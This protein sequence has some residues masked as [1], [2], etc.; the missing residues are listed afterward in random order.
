M[1]N[2]NLSSE[3]RSVPAS[4]GFYANDITETIGNTPLVRLRRMTADRG[5]KAKVLVKMEFLNPTGSVKDRMVVYVLRQAIKS[6]ELKPGGTI[7]EATSGNTG[8]AVAMFAAVN[9]YKAILTVPDK[10]SREKVD[11]LKAF[12]AKVYICPSDV[13]ADSPE[14]YYETGKRLHRE[15]S[16]SYWLGQYFN[17]NNV[18]AHYRTTGPEIWR[19]TGGQIDVLVGGIGTG[20][21]ISGTG[22]FL[23]EMIQ[24]IEVV[25]ADPV[26][27]IYYNYH[28]NKSLVDPNVYMVEGIGDDMLCP[29]VDFS[30]I[31][32]IY[33]VTDE[34]C[35]KTGRELT[36]LE[37]IFGGGSSGAAVHVA[38]KHAVNLDADKTMV[39]ILP[40]SGM[41][42]MSKMY[43]DDWM[44][45]KGFIQ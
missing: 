14:S 21:T 37:G 26:G 45:S 18:E 9:G 30:I 2:V 15:T 29:T 31:D 24:D 41:K 20:G 19:Q 27:S 13:S 10:M 3:G 35:F 1:R 28:K 39:V 8:A 4:N 6:G 23:K 34:E 33:Q 7:V 44:R 5:I 22:R 17:L 12:G 42:Y 43:S 40:D 32:S 16:D 11:M 25:A 38:L 36:R